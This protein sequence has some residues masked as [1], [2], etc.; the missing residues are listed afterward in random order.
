MPSRGIRNNNPG[1]IRHSA[2]KWMGI[3]DEQP[4]PTFVCFD[5]PKYGIRALYKILRTYQ[6][7]HGLETVEE[8]INRWAPPAEND[9]AA[10][11]RSV[12]G[13]I[14]VSPD[15]KIDLCDRE[16]AEKL[17]AAIIRHENGEQP[18]EEKL[19]RAA[20]NLAL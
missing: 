15:T 17:V 20:I 5:E 19:I 9:T 3:S 16:V 2:I 13:A 1:N 8:M 10:Y 12:A 4:D 18:Y 14:G 7:K 11:V 6:D